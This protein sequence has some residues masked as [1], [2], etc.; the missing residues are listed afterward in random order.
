[1]VKKKTTIPK[2]A[3]LPEGKVAVTEESL[4]KMMEQIDAQNEKIAELTKVHAATA[5]KGRLQNYRDKN[6]EKNK[7][8]IRLNLW[9]DKIVI[10][11]DRMSMNRCEKNPQGHWDED[12]KCNLYL[13][14]GTEV[15]DLDYSIRNKRMEQVDA[16]VLKRKDSDDTFM[17]NGVETNRVILDV[18]TEDGTEV[19][20]DDRFVN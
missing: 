8:I 11:W 19:S 1:M 10:G 4:K 20:I 2:E 5:D 13:I 3:K 18:I 6:Q 12:L 7:P 9:E 15:K 16:T 17:L 14:D